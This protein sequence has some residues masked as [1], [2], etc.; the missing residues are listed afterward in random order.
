MILFSDR[1]KFEEEFIRWAIGHQVKITAASVMVYLQGA[2]SAWVDRLVEDAKEKKGFSEKED[3]K[4]KGKY[5]G[6]PDHDAAGWQ[7][8]K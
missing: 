4:P 2:G 6:R 8:P 5:D 3:G 1:L 7:P